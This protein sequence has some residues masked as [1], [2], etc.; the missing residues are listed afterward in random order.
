LP[1]CRSITAAVCLQAQAPEERAGQR[2]AG[3]CSLRKG[4]WG[5]WRGVEFIFLKHTVMLEAAENLV[6]GLS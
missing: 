6:K 3:W 2:L 1:P 5:G 4:T